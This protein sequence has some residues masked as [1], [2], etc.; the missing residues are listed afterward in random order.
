MSKF[1]SR[2]FHGSSHCLAADARDSF[3]LH[4]SFL[5]ILLRNWHVNHRDAA[6]PLQNP[7]SFFVVAKSINNISYYNHFR[8]DNSRI[9]WQT[10]NQPSIF[11]GF[12][13]TQHM[14]NMPNN[15]YVEEA[16]IVVNIRRRKMVCC[17]K[18]R[19]TTLNLSTLHGDCTEH[20]VAVPRLLARNTLPY[21]KIQRK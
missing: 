15:K 14:C 18:K 11:Y 5:I 9:V 4:F 17:Q 2:V 3:P 21:I 7:F 16:Y 10:T 12:M 20:M 1:G 13:S 8:N 6:Y 19:K